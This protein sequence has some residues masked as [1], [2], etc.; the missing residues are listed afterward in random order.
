MVSDL[1]KYSV[2]PLVF[3]LSVCMMLVP[4]GAE[5]TMLVV[6]DDFAL[7]GNDSGYLDDVW[8]LISGPM[9]IKYTYDSTG[10]VD[11]EG[12]FAYAQFGVRETG[13]PNINPTWLSDGVGIWVLMDSDRSVDT[14]DPDPNWDVDDVIHLQ[15][16]GGVYEVE[17]DI[18]VVLQE[19]WLYPYLFDRDGISSHQESNPLQVD[20]ATYST[21]GEY[22][23]VLELEAVNETHGRA[24]LIVNGLYQGFSVDG[25]PHS[26]PIS[27]PDME[28]VVDDPEASFVGSWWASSQVSGYIGDGYMYKIEGVGS[29]TSTW[30]F[31]IPQAGDWEVYARW[32]SSNNRATDA[33]FTIKHADGADTIY[34]DQEV[35]GGEWNSLGV[36]PFGEGG[37]SVVLSDLADEVVIADAIRLVL[38]EVAWPTISYSPAG[39][40]F[41]GDMKNMQVFFGLKS[42]GVEQSV[43]FRDISVQGC[44]T[45]LVERKERVIMNLDE[46][47][48]D[49]KKVD[50]EIDK[51]IDKIE[52]S[53]D[54]DLWEDGFEVDIKHGHKVFDN[55]EKAVKHGMKILKDKKTSEEVKETIQNSI[56]ELISVDMY[57]A[58]DKYQEA[59]QYSGTKKVDHELEKALKESKKAFEELNKAPKKGK[60]IGFDKVIKH[61]EKS[62]KSSQKA[63]KHAEKDD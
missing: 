40:T 17:Y 41:S 62:W 42:P 38:R 16:R 54:G 61:L 30:S 11:S 31:D 24:F 25:D 12:D 55:E 49:N 57:L 37:G 5:A 6:Y 9:T 46:T 35:N 58:E 44:I 2:G 48:F 23:V 36:Y 19:N 43:A 26:A 21:R 52:K 7:A 15:K 18:P 59:L 29:Y 22:D 45:S 14:F 13:F 47:D 32:T 51:M 8:D 63:I 1:K 39:M 56:D 10:L 34:V 4:V 27:I 28:I 50:H 60:T 3:A 53:L 33:P 20:G